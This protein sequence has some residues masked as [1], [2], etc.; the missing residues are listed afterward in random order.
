LGSG[1]F[2]E[3]CFGLKVEAFEVFP[4]EIHAFFDVIDGFGWYSVK[5]CSWFALF[6]LW[7][8]LQLQFPFPFEFG[9]LKVG[10]LCLKDF[11]SWC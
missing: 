2:Y 6:K 4:C 3:E 5:R 1:N 10:S 7:L 8:L 9:A 11:G